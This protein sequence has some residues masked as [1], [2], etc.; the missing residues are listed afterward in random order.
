MA[1]FTDDI[2]TKNIVIYHKD[3]VDGMAAAWCF[4]E[5]MNRGLFAGD[6]EF[7]AGVYGERVPDVYGKRVFMVDFS[8]KLDIM[9]MICQYAKEVIL[10]DHHKSALEALWPLINEY[11]N[12]NMDDSTLTHS[13]AMIAW[14]H[15]K[16]VSEHKVKVPHALPLIEDYDLWRF[17]HPDTR[18]MSHAIRGRPMTLES[19][20]EI[21]AYNLTDFKKFVKEGEVLERAF[22]LTV[23]NLIPT[24]TRMFQLWREYD[25]IPLANVNH[26]YASE[27][28]N[29]LSVG[30]PFAA[31]YY[32]DD[33]HRVFSLRSQ[34][35]GA[36]VSVIAAKYGGGGHATS[37]G[38]KVNRDHDLA[39]I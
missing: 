7:H 17:T 26:M 5:A 33:K 30:H 8:Y 38:F 3:C 21:M 39:K 37:A 34:K 31:T 25:N 16:R 29:R 12:F 27:V 32:D 23:T 10:L 4:W 20:D 19:Y 1:N 22:D 24:V 18:P 14:K 6:V 11:D 2:E 15:I 13:G 28:G 36:D 35:D 9:E